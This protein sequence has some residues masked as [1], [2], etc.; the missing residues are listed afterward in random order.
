[1]NGVFGR[2]MRVLGVAVGLAG[3]ATSAQATVT[4]STFVPGA[5]IAGVVGQNNTIA[6]TYAGNKFVGSVYTGAS[7]LQLFSTD[8]NGGNV[9]L[10]GSPLP[11]GGGEVVVGASL[12]Q[13]GFGKGDIYAAPSNNIYHYSNSGGAP[14]FF[15]STDDGSTVRQIFFDPGNTFGGKMLVTTSSGHILSFDGTGTRTLI[16]SVGEDTEGMDIASTAYGQY[17][18]QLLVASENSGKIRAVSPG[19]VVTVLKSSS[20]G[21][22][23]IQLA[24]TV[25]VVPLDFGLSGNPLEGFY[26]ANYPVDIQKAGDTTEFAPY[27]GDAIVTSEFSSNSPL[28][29]LYYEGDLLD[30]FTLTLIGNMPNQSED[31]IF[32]TAQRIGDTTN[33]PEPGSL[34]LVAAALA[35]LA[36]VKLRRQR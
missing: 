19:G 36:G 6:F 29:A 32:V 28:W 33:V 31:G 2:A 7:N 24:E 9:Q 12:G 35:A 27:L 10:F 1:M 25:S 16:A 26:V 18:G 17:A 5:S 23:F 13:A 30:T 4:F 14:T 8:L 34:V 20:G 3:L 22:I 11:S 15:G 21:D